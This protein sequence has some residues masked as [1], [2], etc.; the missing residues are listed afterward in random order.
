MASGA[1]DTLWGRLSKGAAGTL[2]QLEGAK[3]PPALAA[4]R[5]DGAKRRPALQ[6]LLAS[7]PVRLALGPPLAPDHRFEEVPL[8][9]LPA[10]MAVQLDVLWRR[11]AACEP[12]RRAGLEGAIDRV[13]CE[14]YGLSLDDLMRLELG[15]EDGDTI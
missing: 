7:R 13:V 6:A 14:L 8:P 1:H 2:G 3:T 4:W 15:W 5:S 12:D 10:D 9:A 11:L